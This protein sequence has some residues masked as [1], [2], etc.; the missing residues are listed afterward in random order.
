MNRAFL[1][2]LVNLLFIVA[3]IAAFGVTGGAGVHLVYVIALFALCTTPIFEARA[4]NGP[5]S[6]LV[7][8]SLDYFIMYGALD[9]QHLFFGSEAPLPPSQ[10][11]LSPAEGVILVGAA[12]VQVCYRLA[13]RWAARRSSPAPKDWT[14]PMLVLVGIT[15]WIVCTRLSWEF[16]V[17]IIS[18]ATNEAVKR[19]LESLHPLQVMIFM[20]A[21]MTQPLAIL[22]LAYAQ[23]RYRRPY[24]TALVVALVIFQLYFG[25]VIDFKTEALIGGVLVVL[26]HLLVKGRVPMAWV[27]LMLA[28]IAVGFPILQANRVVRDERAAN[29]QKVSQDVFAAFKQALEAKKRVNTGEE[30]AQTALERLTLKGSVEVIVYGTGRY[31][32]FQHGYTLTPLITTF[33][34]RILWSDK[35]SIPTG[36]IMNRT[37]HLSESPDTYISPSH[38]GELYW[39]FGWAGVVVGMALIGL[40]LGF[41]GGRFNLA[42]AATVTR[43]LVILITVRFLILAAEGEFATQY[44]SW[45]R[46]MLGIGLLHLLFARKAQPSAATPAAARET[47]LDTTLADARPFPNLMS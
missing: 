32:P 24:M 1:Y 15:L 30:R 38:L 29:S 26:T 37:F 6:L 39:N 11:A 16:T 5:Y 47:G 44:V 22:I 20:L 43:I 13:C 33:I 21:R 23:C 36:Q 40:L 45:M 17:H 7:L 10:S 2:A 31:A 14:E 9:V 27:A 3:A 28:I 25:F 12:L 46:S 8:F 35:P 19:G 34:P 42:Q 4:V 18:S 41:I